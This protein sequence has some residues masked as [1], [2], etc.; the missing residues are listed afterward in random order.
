MKPG[1][2]RRGRATPLQSPD[3]STVK[4]QSN[5]AGLWASEIAARWILSRSLNLK[6]RSSSA[7]VLL[8]RSGAL[9]ATPALDTC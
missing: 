8:S 9:A 2:M 3:L 1:F 6:L 7:N 5:Q 4:T